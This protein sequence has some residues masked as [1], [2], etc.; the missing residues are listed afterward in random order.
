MN[1]SSSVA[2]CLQSHHRQELAVKVLSKK[3]KISHLAHQE[4]VSVYQYEN[5]SVDTFDEFWT[6]SSKGTYFNRYIKDIYPTRLVSD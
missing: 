5:V 1:L 4:G 6:S 2:S 3:G